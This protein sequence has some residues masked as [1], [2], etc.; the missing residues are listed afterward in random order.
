VAKHLI[1]E[2]VAG[3]WRHTS[4]EASTGEARDSKTGQTIVSR[5]SATRTREGTET[6]SLN[7]LATAAL[8]RVRLTSG[9]GAGL[10]WFTSQTAETVTACSS[11]LAGACDGFN[12]QFRLGLFS[13]QCVMGVDVSVTSRLQ[14]FVTY[15][16]SQ[17]FSYALGE[18]SMQ[19]GLRIGLK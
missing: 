13:M 1:I 4:I 8:G 18:V 19:T 3:G 16:L 14:A 15:R 5:R 6:V 10:G 2:G 9:A 17:P 12:E 7:A 11:T